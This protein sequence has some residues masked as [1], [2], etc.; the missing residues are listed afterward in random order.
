M[1]E[2]GEDEGSL[3]TVVVD[4]NPSPY[5][6][7]DGECIMPRCLDAVAAFCNA[8]M[9]LSPLNKI[10]VIGCH[11]KQ[12]CFLFPTPT[13][14]EA[15]DFRPADGQYELFADI[16]NSILK[17]TKKLVF[18][19]SDTDVYTESL[20]AGAMT[21]AL[22][23]IHRVQK[24]Q[25]VETK[26]PSRILVITASGDSASQYMNF[27]NVF[28]TSQKE[29]VLIDACVVEKDSGLLQ[30]GCDIT[31]GMYL[32]VQ[33]ISALLQYLLWIFLPGTEIRKQMILPPRVHVDYRAA[34]FCHRNLIEIG[35][36]CSVCLSIF[37]TFSPICS[38]CQTAF[39]LGPLPNIIGKK[40]R[41]QVP[42]RN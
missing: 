31:G 18:Q 10:A 1:A 24:Q 15:E 38:T 9:M 6:I 39:K 42:L 2:I 5:L 41:K 12:S 27:M 13:S 30:Q 16:K 3:I 23:Y 20:I 37:C 7:K 11:T 22:C 32:K 25:I 21:M 34:C 36:V 19:N 26:I 8:H 29:G 17:N 40:K 28:F 14:S 35:Y 33:N 4:L